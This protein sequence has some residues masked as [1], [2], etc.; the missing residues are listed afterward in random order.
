MDSKWASEEE[1]L[2]E[3]MVVVMTALC[4]QVRH[5]IGMTIHPSI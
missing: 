4:C 2:A 3:W 1:G 5:I